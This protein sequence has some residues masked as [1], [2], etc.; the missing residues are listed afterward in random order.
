MTTEEKQ[1][2]IQEGQDAPGA[3]AKTKRD[4]SPAG[5]PGGS[6]KEPGEKV[7]HD[8]H[9]PEIT[10]ATF[11]FSLNSS[12]LVNLGLVEEPTTGKKEKNLLLAR[13]TIDILGML[14]KKTK[15]NLSNEEEQLLKNILHD[16]RIMY[17]KVC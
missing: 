8:I 10:F 11:V 9:M 1:F 6:G 14:E 13:Q 15:G 4:A 16:L 5:E 7:C 2:T 3:D 17:V 12:A